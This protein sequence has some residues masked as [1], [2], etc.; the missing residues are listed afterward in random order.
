MV[1]FTHHDNELRCVVEMRIDCCFV[2]LRPCGIADDA[3]LADAASVS[4]FICD[5]I[6]SITLPASDCGLLRCSSG[7]AGQDDPERGEQQ[8]RPAPAQRRRAKPQDS[9][10]RRSWG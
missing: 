8:Q 1:R 9:R 7:P 4:A 10:L 2:Y 5:S 6:S 3:T